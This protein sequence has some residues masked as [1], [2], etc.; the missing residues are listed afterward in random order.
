MKKTIMIAVVLGV[1]AGI[2]G[3]MALRGDAGPQAAPAATVSPA[4]GD[5]VS[6][7]GTVEGARPEVSLRPEVAGILTAVKVREN[8][9]VE[10]GQVLAELSNEAQKAQ[11]ELAR[12]ELAVAREH[13][14]KLKAGERAQVIARARA[15]EAAKAAAHEKAR[16][17]VDRAQMTASGLSASDRDAFR[18]QLK[19]A[20]ADWDKAKADLAL[21]LEGARVEDLAAAQAQVQV[22]EAKL[23]AA[24]AELAKTRL[25]APTSGKVLQVFAEPGEMALPTSSQPVLIMADL[26]KRRVRAFVEELDVDRIEVGLPATVTADGLPGKTFTGKVGVAVQRMGKRAP[27]SDAPNELKDV[28][29]REVLIDLDGGDELPTNLRVQVHIQAKQQEKR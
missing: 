16:N 29:F 7:N 10:K 6:A 28:Y 17:D 4:A 11:V 12:G 18:T 15:E 23:H 20:Q 2:G 5:Q 13:L 8:D 14:N 21:A 25:T 19:L 22:A 27:Q 26:S 1:T 24:T 9:A 3:R